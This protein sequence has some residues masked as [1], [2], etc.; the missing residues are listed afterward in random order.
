SDG[1]KTRYEHD[2]VGRLR[3]SLETDDAGNE[4]L[5]KYWLLDLNSRPIS[6]TS[7]APLAGGRKTSE[8]PPGTNFA[9][10]D[11]VIVSRVYYDGCGKPALQVSSGPDGPGGAK[12]FLT[13]QRNM[14]NARQM[15]S[16]E[17]P[18]EFVPDLSFRPFPAPDPGAVRIRY[19]A[20]GSK[21]ETAGPDPVHHRVVR[22]N[23]TITHFDGAAAGAFGSPTPPG[24]ASRIERF[25]ARSRLYRIEEATGD[26]RFITTSYDLTLDGHIEVVRD[27]RG[28][29][30]TRYTFA[31][32]DNIVRITNRDAGTRSYYR[33]T[34]GRVVERVSADGSKVFYSFDRLG[35]MTRIEQAAPGGVRQLLREIIYDADPGLPSAGRF[36]EGRMAVVK[37]ASH[38]IHYSY[39]RA[40]KIVR[41]EVT[42]GDVTLAT[43]RDFNLQGKLQAI[44]YPD[45]KR[46]QYTLDRS[47][48]P[49][50]IP[51]VLSKITY[52]ADG[53]VTG[54]LL[55][56]GVAVS[57]PRDTVSR[58][59]AE[60]TARKDGTT[61]RSLSY[62]YDSVGNVTS[63]RDEMPGDIQFQNFGY[64][65]L[66]R[67]ANF[68]VRRN[69][70]ASAI[71]SQGVYSYDP[72]GNL[73]RLE[74]VRP[75]TM[76]YTD[77][78]HPGRLTRVASATATQNTTYDARGH[79]S[80]FG[81]LA[82]LEFDALDR[83]VHVV[84]SNGTELRMAYDPQNRLVLKQITQGG[85]TRQIRYAAGLFE[86]HETHSVRHIHLA[87]GLIA[88]E[89]I[90]SG[91][92]VS[93][94]VVYYL[95]DHHGTV[96]LATDATGKAI[97]NQR[98]SPFGS[99]LMASELDRY[100]GR[101][102]D[103]E[104]GL[105]HLGARYYAPALGRFIS[106]DWF[107]LEN[108]SKPAR[109]PQG[110][111]LY[112]YSINNPLAFKDPG[113]MWFFV[114]LAIAFVV[115]FIAGT[116]SGLVRGQGWGSLLTGLETGLTTAIG[117]ALGAGVGFSLG[118]I[119]GAGSAVALS[120]VFG[121]MGGLN[122]LLSGMHQIY[123]WEHPGGWLAFLSDSTW[124][125]L[126]TSLGNIVQV[127]NIIGGAKYRS[128]LSFRQ[129][130]N[131][132]E[133]GI[134][135]SKDDAFT[136][137]NVIS[138]AG[139]GGKGVSMNLIDNHESIH[140]LQ[141]R[142]FGPLF[143]AVYIVWLVGGFIVG[144]VFWLFHTDH[145]YGS[146]IETMA[147]YDNPWEYWAYSNQNYWQPTGQK[148]FDPIAAWS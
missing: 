26:G 91:A 102:K 8:F 97:Q 95:T 58:R 33:D 36:L 125:L 76:S 87:N 132:Y 35:R 40:G 3:A 129:N 18:P 48:T 108:P 79:I 4:Q 111:N 10:L 72:E 142:I 61:I 46:V 106:P 104:T 59:F 34:A 24:P 131:V 135:I 90:M 22:D 27:D 146:I 128:D 116:I 68:T 31:G 5:V 94:T 17:F 140:I 75:L 134:Y 43:A 130:R 93:S 117:F 23:F 118:S 114:A 88:S 78:A 133:G 105:V 136:Q 20:E 52:D 62:G 127:L 38:T 113:G 7:V 141:N 51:G 80:S 126:G 86:R 56:N 123:D 54:Y 115:G 1:R 109:M 45:G 50:E 9:A 70:G 144:S 28:A 19:D 89:K 148:G 65:G 25:D 37:E 101:E 103:T 137:G 69:D 13:A 14:L 12:R 139:R 143:Q 15:V 53:S 107:V 6:V 21:E 55:A 122:G 16:A 138:N 60:A 82:K 84:K 42:T 120:G 98:Y 83:L 66:Y 29:E 74:E 67:L 30:M 147:Y 119:F 71:L 124:G 73:L 32:P 110:F 112:S 92:P 49:T 100:L 41:E 81:D 47:G 145:D 11:G 99:P 96:V 63:I 77:A 2:A 121:T 64:D 57:T 39:N 44:T 85:A